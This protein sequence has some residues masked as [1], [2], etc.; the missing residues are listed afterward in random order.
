MRTYV[1]R[2]RTIKLK[3]KLYVDLKFSQDTAVR[4]HMKAIVMKKELKKRC[5]EEEIF[6]TEKEYIL[7]IRPEQ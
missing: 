3:L 6:R 4:Y 5:T 1:M 7:Q 2:Q